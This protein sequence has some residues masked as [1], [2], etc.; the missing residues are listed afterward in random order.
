MRTY[1][2]CMKNA[3]VVMINNISHEEILI[4]LYSLVKTIQ[5]DEEAYAASLAL[6][7]LREPVEHTES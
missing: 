7:T 2:C 1:D 6:G 3:L 4:F 5:E